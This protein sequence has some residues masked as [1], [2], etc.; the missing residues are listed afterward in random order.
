MKG[1]FTFARPID[2]QPALVTTVTQLLNLHNNGN[3]PPNKTYGSHTK[4]P[5]PTI[6]L[7]TPQS[8]PRSHIQILRYIRAPPQN[9]R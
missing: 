1:P 9:R 8:M 6:P 4:P 7:H 3:A 2:I 5:L